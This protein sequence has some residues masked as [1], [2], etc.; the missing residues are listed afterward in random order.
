MHLDDIDRKI[1]NLIQHE[2]PVTKR[3]FSHIAKAIGIE[4]KDAFE[5]IKKLKERGIIRRI[6]PVIERKKIGYVSVLCGLY[7]EK[8][9]MEEIAHAIN[10]YAGVTHNYERDGELNLWF[11]V[12]AKTKEE[13]DSFL[14]GLE[15]MFSV[16]IYR[17]PEK[18]VF[19]IKTYFPV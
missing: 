19:K 14:E 4:E 17:F 1:L 9:K 15:R 10:T 2:F 5:R 18:K 3:P 16:K 13:I 8:D 11:T 7:V 6:G 12:T